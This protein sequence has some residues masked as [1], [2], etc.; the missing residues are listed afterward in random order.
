MFTDRWKSAPRT[1]SAESPRQD[2][3]PA[4]PPAT[5]NGAIYSRHSHGLEQFFARIQGDAGLT[6][7]DLA[8]A[9]QSN[10]NFVTS[11]GHRLYTEDLLYLLDAEFGGGDFYA[12]Q[13]VPERI[14]AFLQQALDF[15]DSHFDGALVWD[16]LEYLAP[17]LLKAVVD[18]LSRIM[19]PHSYLLAIFH[20]DEK[21]ETVPVFSYRI[22]EAGTLLLRQRDL[23]RPAQLFNNRAV[24]KLFRDF[25]SVKFFLTRDS[26]RE[27]IVRR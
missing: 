11:L 2:R 6:I 27:V 3:F 25:E 8:G 20:A 4:S 22:A 1:G 17:P 14:E 24:E 15:P 13:C 16:L 9:S 10:I 5:G 26:L 19:R 21:L 12:S 23:K 18:R 7:L